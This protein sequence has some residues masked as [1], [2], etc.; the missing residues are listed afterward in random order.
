MIDLDVLPARLRLPLETGPDGDAPGLGTAGHLHAAVSVVL[1]RAPTAP[2][3][4]LIKRAASERDPWSGHMAFPGGKHEAGDADLLATACRETLEET[5]LALPAA[6]PEWVGRLPG[7]SPR[8]RGSDRLPSLRV[9]PFLFRVDGAAEARVASR[10]VERIH[11]VSLAELADSSREG[12]YR[13]P[14]GG[15]VRSFPSID[16]VGEQVWGLTWRV[17]DQLMDGLGLRPSRVPDGA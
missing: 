5:G 8:G 7:V 11:W 12:L 1:R 13:M 10:E 2:E 3:V 4:L 9:T 16:V 14:V 15:A 17:L 6:A